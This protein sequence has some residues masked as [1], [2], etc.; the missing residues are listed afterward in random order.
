MIPLLLGFFSCSFS[1]FE[2]LGMVGRA[3]L[4]A[5]VFVAAVRWMDGLSPQD[6]G[7]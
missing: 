1:G 5:D 7:L 6:P 2:L 3:E 4:S